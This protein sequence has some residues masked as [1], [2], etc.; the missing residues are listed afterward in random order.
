MDLRRLGR[1]PELLPLIAIFV[2]L[3][4]RHTPK[5]PKFCPIKVCVLNVKNLKEPVATGQIGHVRYWA[6]NS[7]KSSYGHRRSHHAE[8]VELYTTGTIE[9]FSPT[10]ARA[11]LCSPS[12]SSS[13]S[14]SPSPGFLPIHRKRKASCSPSPLDLSLEII[15]QSQESK[16][17]FRT[18]SPTSAVEAKTRWDTEEDGTPG[19]KRISSEYLVRSNLSN[20]KPCKLLRGASIRCSHY[21]VAYRLSKP[22]AYRLSWWLSVLWSKRCSFCGS[23]LPEYWCIWKVPDLVSLARSF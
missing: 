11:N 2:V 4:T 8:D 12:L 3:L 16:I 10:S 13:S 7:W 18:T 6:V 22:I 14:S 15:S 21:P 9:M 20:Y 5:I 23:G 1:W 17:E 19:P